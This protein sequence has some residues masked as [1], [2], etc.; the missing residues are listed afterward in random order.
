MLGWAEIRPS[1]IK[2]NS[3]LTGTQY[4]AVERE[5]MNRCR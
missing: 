1:D 2:L 4:R 3:S 5:V